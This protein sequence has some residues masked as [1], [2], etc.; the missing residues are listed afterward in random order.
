[1]YLGV[2][3]WVHLLWVFID[4]SIDNLG[5]LND[6]WMYTLVEI[7]ESSVEAYSSIDSSS[8]SNQHV[9]SFITFIESVSE[10]A[11]IIDNDNVSNATFIDGRI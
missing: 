5:S 7:L 6:L 10:S 9:S 1:M 11:N 8:F 4:I 2:E 3:V